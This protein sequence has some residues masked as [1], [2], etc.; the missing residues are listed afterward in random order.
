[1][2]INQ[3]IEIKTSL[4]VGK[5]GIFAA[6]TLELGLKFPSGENFEINGMQ[7]TTAKA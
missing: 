7:N 2:Q 1:M 6:D 5:D 3:G 4:T